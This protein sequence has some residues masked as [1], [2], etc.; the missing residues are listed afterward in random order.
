M[1]GDSN[2]IIE[3]AVYDI[4]IEEWAEKAARYDRLVDA[5]L[6]EIYEFAPT[7]NIVLNSD[8]DRLIQSILQE[9]FAFYQK[10]GPNGLDYL[11]CYLVENPEEE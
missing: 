1:D 8:M 3:E 10:E 7:E 6:Q 5:L 2:E 9:C 11:D 4:P